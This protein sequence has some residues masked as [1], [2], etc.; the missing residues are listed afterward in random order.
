[1]PQPNE[2]RA[3]Q[4]VKLSSSLPS[5]PSRKRFHTPARDAE[6]I[7]KCFPHPHV[8]S[9]GGGVRKEKQ[10]KQNKSAKQPLFSP[11]FAP[12]MQKTQLSSS[13]ERRGWFR[14]RLRRS[15]RCFPP[16]PFCLPKRKPPTMENPEAKRVRTASVPIV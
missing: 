3:F 15:R 13:N 2:R 1:M 14:D 8:K 12:T 10:K 9:G 7:D 5:Q 4:S 11:H 6:I 16:F